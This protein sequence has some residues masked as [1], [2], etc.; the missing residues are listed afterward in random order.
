[1]RV[2]AQELVGVN[3]REATIAVTAVSTCQRSER[4]GGG[5]ERA[6]TNARGDGPPA[7]SWS[8]RRRNASCARR[9]ADEE[10]G[11]RAPKA[12]APILDPPKKKKDKDKKDKKGKRDKKREEEK[13]VVAP[14]AGWLVADCPADGGG[15]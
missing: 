5:S 15:T 3:S 1:M 12:I 2:D 10:E 7:P 13:E 9:E 8:P 6:S 11:R 14:F 4:R